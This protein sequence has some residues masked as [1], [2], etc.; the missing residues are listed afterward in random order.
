MSL[1]ASQVFRG[2]IRLFSHLI[3]QFGGF[4]LDKFYVSFDI[5]S[6]LGFLISAANATSF[7]FERRRPW[8]AL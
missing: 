6:N 8:T 2:G 7:L 4:F 3:T 1:K 5:R